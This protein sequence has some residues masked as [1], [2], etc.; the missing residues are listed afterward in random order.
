MITRRFG[1]SVV[2]GLSL[3]LWTQPQS[4]AQAA[5]GAADSACAD[6]TQA[7]KQERARCADF[8][9][10]LTDLRVRMASAR[11]QQDALYQ[12]CLLDNPQNPKVC[13]SIREQWTS[14]VSLYQQEYDTLAQRGCQPSVDAQTLYRTCGPGAHP[15]SKPAEV[16]KSKVPAAKSKHPGKNQPMPVSN[17]PQQVPRQTDGGAIAQHG[18]AQAPVQA[19]G[20]NGVANSAGRSGPPVSAPAQAPSMSGPPARMIEPK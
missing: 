3:F 9:Q 7:Y 10:H 17:R 1:S 11:Q 15:D 4:A 16:D 20:N 18:A 13:D 5:A 2:L 12:Q 19:G 8:Q 14:N 6:M